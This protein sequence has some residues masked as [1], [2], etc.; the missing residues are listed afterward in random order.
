MKKFE[1]VIILGIDGAGHFFREANTPEFDKIFLK[2]GAYTYDGLSSD[3][4]ISA[5]AWGS[6]MTGV[7][8]AIHG[9]TN[10]I[11]WHHTLPEDVPFST[12][13][14]KI[15]E[16]NP[17]AELGAFC[18]WI[19]LIRGLIETNVVKTVCVNKDYL[20]ADP[21]C[22]YI[23]DKKPDLLFVH[24][25]SVDHAGHANGYGTEPHLK[26][27]EAVDKIIGKIYDSV[28]GAGILDTTLFCVI[29]DHGGT[30]FP[31]PDGEGFNGSHGG[32]TDNEKYITFA[33]RGNGVCKGSQIGPFN[34]RDVAAIVQYA[35]DLPMP[36][37]DLN[38][39]TSQLPSGLFEGVS[40]E[41][42]D[43]SGE[44]S[45]APAISL[46]NGTSTPV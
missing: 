26:A 8:P 42:R 1:H 29:S 44:N 2:D 6:M 12:F 35:F 13:Y 32:W 28:A 5:E 22:N 37:F 18:E 19:P 40:P 3:P 43:I 11:M 33:A 20:M 23:Q 34:I 15:W 16:V 17:R 41:Y 24:C 39:W 27:I 7:S 21:I 30:C 36:E 31:N 9:L 46:K 4:T 38:G 10:D 14:R 25:D 45:A